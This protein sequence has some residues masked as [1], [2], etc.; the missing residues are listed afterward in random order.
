MLQLHQVGYRFPRGTQPAVKDVD[1]QV[2]AGEFVLLTGPTGCGKSTLL[3]LCAGLL[4]RHGAG[5]VLGGVQI[6]GQ[7]PGSIPPSLRVAKIGFVSQQPVDQLVAGT[8]GDELAFA[9][10]SAGWDGA[11]IDARIPELLDLIGLN[12]DPDRSVEALSGGQK[13]RLVIGAAI[14]GGAQLLLLDEPLAQ[15]DPAGA[16]GL[17]GVLRRLAD[18]GHIVLMVEHRLGPCLDH[19]DR[20]IQME[21]GRIL[22]DQ[23]AAEVDRQALSEAG[24]FIPRPSAKTLLATD[25]EPDHPIAPEGEIRVSAQDLSFTW[26]QTTEPVLHSISLRFHAGERIA[27]LGPNG[28]GKSTLIGA[29]ARSLDAEGV[30]T[31]GSV[32]DVP[33]DP[34]LALFCSTVARELAYGPA[35]HGLSGTDLQERVAQSATALSLSDLMDRAPQALSRGQRL[36]VAVA[37]TLSCAPDVLLLD[38]PSAGQD[39]IQ[40][41]RMMVALQEAMSEGVLVFATHDLELARRHATRILTMDEGRLQ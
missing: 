13:Q 16:R 22:S 17:V 4:Q 12:L 34:D 40:V 1:L 32:I 36:R 18:Q 23:A 21:E 9:L 19:V 37:A 2:Q 33:Q 15:L 5:E 25:V 20:L 6:D 24:F 11:R 31:I 14:A 10:E 28:S 7:D 29:L 38:E 3:R 41:E 39:R 30:M 8:L 26:P 35:D 27:L